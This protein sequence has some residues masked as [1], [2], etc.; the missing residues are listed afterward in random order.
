MS[1]SVP[2]PLQ[3]P[4]TLAAIGSV[5]VFVA[6]V[7]V[8]ARVLH[9]P[10]LAAP[11]QTIAPPVIDGSAG[12]TLFGAQPDSGPHDAIQLLGILAFDAHHAAAIISV[13][14][15]LSQVVRLHGAIA[16]ATTLSEVRSHSIIIARNGVRHEIA[17]SQSPN[18][19]AFVR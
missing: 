8:W 15:E 10:L 14:G 1:L 6:V 3:S 2:R 18:P 16:D 13:G 17:L 7:C 19:N 4:T 12:A 11:A 9:A 5:A